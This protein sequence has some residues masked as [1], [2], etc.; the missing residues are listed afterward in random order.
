ML[1]E[2]HPKIIFLNL[3]HLFFINI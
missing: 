1:L 3:I 2:V